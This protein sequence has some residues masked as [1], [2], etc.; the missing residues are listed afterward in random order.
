[1][2]SL[3]LAALQGQLDREAGRRRRLLGGTGELAGR[4]RGPGRRDRAR[5]GDARPRRGHDGHPRGAG[6]GHADGQG[7]VD[8]RVP[9][10][11]G[12]Q[13]ATAIVARAK[14][15]GITHVYPR[16]GSHWDGF[17]ARQSMD[18]FLPVAHAAGL[19][20]FGWDFPRL[21]DSLPSDIERARTMI[22][23]TSSSGDRLDGFSADIETINEGSHVTPEIALVY[24][25]ALR[26]IAGPDFTLIATVPRPSPRNR[27]D[28]PLR[29]DRG[30]LRRHR[31]H[32]LLA[33]PPAR[34]RRDRRHGRAGQVRQ[35][36]L[37]GGPG[38][39]RQGRGRPGRACRRPRSCRRS[40]AP[41]STRAPPACRSGRGRR[42]TAP[43]G[44]PSGTPPSSASRRS[45]AGSGRSTQATPADRPSRI[46]TGPGRG[47]CAH[48]RP[49]GWRRGRGPGA[50]PAGRRRSPP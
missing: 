23:F 15:N 5:G 50:W 9:P 12:R 24:G 16:M 22:N 25:R 40:C 43:R 1:M 30:E 8:L 45:A 27:P 3:G 39:R 26:E 49:R 11:R 14:A 7:D 32:G 6:E 34:H 4:G 38:L 18:A 41:P 36:R 33:Q 42:P 17:N 10:H 29:R 13:H 37:P 44:P 21:G 46:D 28:L 47:G 19:K 35:A 2:A 20:V 31:P 48:R